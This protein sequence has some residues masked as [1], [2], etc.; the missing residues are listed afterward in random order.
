M[1][2]N[3]ET[4]QADADNLQ[5]GADNLQKVLKNIHD[6]LVGVNTSMA[7]MNGQIQDIM[8]KDHINKYNKKLEQIAL[9]SAEIGRIFGD[10][11]DTLERGIN[12]LN[13]A[14]R[15]L[16]S[17]KR[18]L[19]KLVNGGIA[20]VDR[21]DVL[22]DL[23]DKMEVIDK[24][25]DDLS[26]MEEL[27]GFL[28]QLK[29]ELDKIYQVSLDLRQ[30]ADK[31]AV[32]PD[33]VENIISQINSALDLTANQ[34]VAVS[35]FLLEIKSTVGDL[36]GKLGT[37]IDDMKIFAEHVGMILKSSISQIDES[38]N[39]LTAQLK[40][41][42]D[43]YASVTEDVKALREILD[44]ESIVERQEKVEES[45]LNLIEQEKQQQEKQQELCERQENYVAKADK[46]AH[47]LEE[48][49]NM[50]DELIS[51]LKE[52][53]SIAG[54]ALA[55]KAEDVGKSLED[56][57]ISAGD[58]VKNKLEDINNSIA[59]KYNSLEEK[60]IETSN[61][62]MDLN[63]QQLELSGKVQEVGT[64]VLEL[65]TIQEGLV[66]KYDELNTNQE[67]LLQQQ[68]EFQSGNQG[69]LDRLNEVVNQREVLTE[70]LR[71]NQQ[72]TLDVIENVMN[73]QREL[74]AQQRTIMNNQQHQL[75][76]MMELEKKLGNTNRNNLLASAGIGAV[77]A[78]LMFGM[79][80]AGYSIF[81]NDNPKHDDGTRVEITTEDEGVSKG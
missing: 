16:A 25:S 53:F 12:S 67:K 65:M 36:N 8:S 59:E 9:S 78:A 66:A 27:R 10:G 1:A 29:E 42:T 15:S 22:G 3:E 52:K 6:Y 50:Q 32:L 49:S 30:S 26:K 41:F 73:A 5:A 17:T 19:G 46:I 20:L 56:K 31:V 64:K 51:S 55:A 38:S 57:F 24:V 77:V 68:E 45:L 75:D 13:K 58:A 37:N 34:Q 7:S 2:V 14:T 11:Q 72:E 47:D 70:K 35:G 62:Q 39:S 48:N 60:Q 28:G 23:K 79:F 63:V 43:G 76:V 21:I 4:L 40:E 44:K 71:S 54:D 61:K 33:D 18:D 74:K 81:G 69:I 80:V